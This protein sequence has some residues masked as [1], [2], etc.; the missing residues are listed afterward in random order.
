MKRDL[1]EVPSKLHKLGY[2][3]AGLAHMIEQLGKSDSSP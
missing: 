1:S 2:K 3:A